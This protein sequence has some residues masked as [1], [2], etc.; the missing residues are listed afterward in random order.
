MNTKT[1]VGGTNNHVRKTY[2]LIFPTSILQ[3]YYVLTAFKPHLVTHYPPLSRRK[4]AIHATTAILY[5]LKG[6][7][8]NFAQQ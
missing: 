2:N 6:T 1:A 7:L 5:N 3:S 4:P 8:K